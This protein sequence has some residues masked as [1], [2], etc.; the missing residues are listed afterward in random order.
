MF[1]LIKKM[2][3]GAGQN[4]TDVTTDLDTIIISAEPAPED[5]KP[6]RFSQSK[7]PT[8]ADA[9]AT[10]AEHF[11]DVRE[12]DLYNS[13]GV[14]K[15]EY[16]DACIAAF[17]FGKFKPM[18]IPDSYR[19]IYEYVYDHGFEIKHDTTDAD[20][21]T[22][23]AEV[24][25][26]CNID[27][28]SLHPKTARVAIKLLW[29]YATVVG[30]K[31]KNN[32]M[33]DMESS[34]DIYYRTFR[35]LH[36]LISNAEARKIMGEFEIKHDTTDEDLVT[37]WAEVEKDNRYAL[38]PDNVRS[39]IKLLSIYSTEGAKTKD[40]PNN[41]RDALNLIYETYRTLH[42]L[43]T[44]AEARKIMGDIWPEYYETPIDYEPPIKCVLKTEIQNLSLDYF[45][46]WT[47]KK[48][49]VN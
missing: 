3:F 47:G 35:G 13:S 9:R 5:F 11:G 30:E 49:R 28:L 10:I 37:F 48:R 21:A 8:V 20:L 38:E 7:Y 24:E 25:K 36:S 2:Y 14:R 46:Y 1:Y 6:W 16:D 42:S 17:K 39:A 43:I 22:F 26:D 40:M 27:G 41:M 23:L 31:T 32:F 15:P 45:T 34:L 33:A 44:N 29:F 19:Y 12:Q 4:Q 18:N